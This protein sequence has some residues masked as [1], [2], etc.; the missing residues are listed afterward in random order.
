MG[1]SKINVK[2][3]TFKT[4]TFSYKVHGHYVVGEFG[5]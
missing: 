5:K 1:I 2:A 4:K 3:E